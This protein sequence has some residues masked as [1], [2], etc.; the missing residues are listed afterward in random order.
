MCAASANPNPQAAA[1]CLSAMA[2]GTVV[3]LLE[4]GR[5]DEFYKGQGG[6]SI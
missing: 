3:V 1:L 6:F 4:A 2:C 5:K